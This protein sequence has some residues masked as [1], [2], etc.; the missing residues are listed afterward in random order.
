MIGKDDTQAPRRPSTL[1]RVAA[2]TLPAL[3]AAASAACVPRP[4]PEQCEALA[5]HIV[6]LSRASQEGRAADIA[7]TVAEEQR[8]ALV[9]RCK[10]EGTRREV[11]CVLEATSLEAIQDCAPRD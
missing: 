6:A 3:L 5:D 10:S 9:E 11:S 7:A 1:V 4:E 2:R 8:E